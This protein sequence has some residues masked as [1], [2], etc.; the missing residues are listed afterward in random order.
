MQD[1]QDRE[2]SVNLKLIYNLDRNIYLL[3]FTGLVM[4][5][6]SKLYDFVVCNYN[7]EKSKLYLV[8]CEQHKI[9]CNPIMFQ[10][11]F[12]SFIF[13]SLSGYLTPTHTHSCT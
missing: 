3:V 11:Q 9:P 8:Y 10:S 6:V 7:L 4:T 2:G 13:T 5:A 12:F 1:N